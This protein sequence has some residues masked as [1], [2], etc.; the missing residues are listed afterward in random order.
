LT[1]TVENLLQQKEKSKANRKQ[2]PP[3]LMIISSSVYDFVFS[4][5]SFVLHTKL[6]EA[7]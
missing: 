4:T 1:Q 7:I 3:K 5:V 6:H 2:N